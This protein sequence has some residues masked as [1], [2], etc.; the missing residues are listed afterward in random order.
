MSLIKYYKLSEEDI[1]QI[2]NEWYSNGMCIDIFQNESGE[3][4]D[5]WCNDRMSKINQ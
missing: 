4:L 1:L 3:E 2:I 5:E